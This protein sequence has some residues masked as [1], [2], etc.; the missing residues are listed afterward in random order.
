M[1]I[2]DEMNRIKQNIENTYSIL[3][4]KGATIPT[5][6]NSDNLAKTAETI[7]TS[8]TIDAIYP[9]GS[10][11]LSVTSQNPK[12]FFGGTWEQIKD[13]FLL[14]AGNTYHNGEVGGEEKHTLTSSEL[15]SHAHGQQMYDA[16][17]KTVK[18]SGEPSG[19]TQTG[20]AKYFGF[21]DAVGT[22]NTKNILSTAP[23]GSNVAHNN[24]PPYLTVYMWKRIK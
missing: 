4:N 9:I 10:I 7:P 16:I 3:S 15:P 6:K 23:V 20:E 24:M 22:L 21:S 8:P 14:A 19:G 1:G 17:S 13:R 5:I 2:Q 11:Y 12:S 18:K